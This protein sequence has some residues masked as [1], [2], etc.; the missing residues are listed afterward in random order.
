MSNY[1]NMVE[2]AEWAVHKENCGPVPP[3]CQ[4][5]RYLFPLPVKTSET[6]KHT[7][8]KQDS[9]LSASLESTGRRDHK[10][11]MLGDISSFAEP[12]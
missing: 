10:L 4:G 3:A 6:F 8:W 5:G 7:A 12:F 9:C 1:G 2:N 11:A